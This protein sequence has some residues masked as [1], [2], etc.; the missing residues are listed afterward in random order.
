VHEVL[1]VRKDAGKSLRIAPLLH[2]IPM[3]P[4]TVLSLRQH[5]QVAILQEEI[6]RRDPTLPSRSFVFDSKRR[7]GSGD[8]SQAIRELPSWSKPNKAQPARALSQLCLA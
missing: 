6:K 2:S 4:A 7:F 1:R 3:L 5:A 8:N